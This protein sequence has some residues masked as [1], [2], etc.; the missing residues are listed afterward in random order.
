MVRIFVFG[1]LG[2]IGTAGEKLA[3][4]AE[5]L[6][7]KAGEALAC[8]AGLS[9][10]ALRDTLEVMNPNIRNV[11]SGD[12]AAHII[13]GGCMVAMKAIKVVHAGASAAVY[14]GKGDVEPA[15][16]DF[17]S[18]AKYAVLGGTGKISRGGLYYNDYQAVYGRDPVNNCG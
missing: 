5:K 17:A 2:F 11:S 10:I 15:I 7:E 9:A 18:Q 16:R 8:G 4:V 12:W 3:P 6:A 1:R 13:C 14:T